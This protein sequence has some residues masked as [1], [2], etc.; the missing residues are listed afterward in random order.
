MLERELKFHVPA[1]Q[2]SGLKTRLNKLG[3]EA[4][5]L[6]ARYFDTDNQVLARANIALRLRREDGIWI[7]TI[8]TPG[9]DELSRIEWNHPR[10]GPTLDLGLYA[11]SHI[12]ELMANVAGRLRCRYIT[13][14]IRLKKVVPTES[15]SAELA[16]DEGAI[17]AN[18]IELSIHEFEIEGVTGHARDLFALSGEWLQ[19][20][21]L[22]L[23]L[24]SK[25]ARGDAIATLS[26]ESHAEDSLSTWDP[27]TPPQGRARSP[28]LSP[29]HVQRLAAAVRA[30]QPLLSPDAGIQ[31]AYLQCANDC[32][33]QII[34]NSGFLA[35]LDSMKT[36]N[37]QRI[38]YVHQIRVGIRRLRACWQLF[39]DV[40]TP[41]ESLRERLKQHF[42]VLGQARDLDVIQTELLPRLM[43]A[44]MPP[45]ATQA[46]IDHSEESTQRA[47]KVAAPE[48]QQTLL[49]LLEHLVLYGDALQKSGTK[50]DAAPL[51][52]KRLNA[53]LERIRRDAKT[54]LNVSWDER[55]ELRKRV[56]RLRYGMEF[57]QGVLDTTQL[58]PLRN[59]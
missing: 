3:A 33:S 57:S 41:P 9:P 31:A 34:R 40:A 14:V 16:Y 12:G 10:P 42:S 48:F 58:T 27:D 24:R 53:W 28:K 20:H 44:G 1:R 55:H 18:G 26:A 54:F 45:D 30:G 49:D 7:Q 4:V 8:K 39:G 43:T 38:E 50:T 11:D 25:A 23:E 17:I 6:H 2:R 19:E 32:M 59:A 46:P 37:E 21:R 51:L 13:H 56:K 22:V 36:S 52:S 47:R 5:E 35:G 29:Q 15:G